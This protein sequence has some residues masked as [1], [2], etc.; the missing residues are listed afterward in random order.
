VTTTTLL[1]G[2][3]IRA[4]FFLFKPQVGSELQCIVS[5][6]EEGIITCLAHGVFK[7]E[8][9]NPPKCWETVFVGQTITAKVLVVEQLAWQ[10][11]RILASLLGVTDDHNVPH[12]IDV[13]D[14]F[15]TNDFESVTDSGMFEYEHHQVSSSASHSR[16]GDIAIAGGD[17]APSIYSKKRKAA[18]D[19]SA[20]EATPS[21]V[22]KKAKTNKKSSP[23]VSE[24]VT[25]S[26]KRTRSIS[27]SSVDS[28]TSPTSQSSSSEPNT[29]SVFPVPHHPVPAQ[30]MPP[31]VAT[32]P[33]KQKKD[34]PPPSPVKIV[35]LPVVT[36]PDK[37]KQMSKKSPSKILTKILPKPSIDQDSD[38]DDDA[39]TGISTKAT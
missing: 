33:T 32:S 13:V 28:D 19:R 35:Q 10:E 30:S 24:S 31:P 37:D 14:E 16:G 9:I 39:T 29:D 7:V 5:K 1:Q 8:V 18:E 23:D 17:I 34:P 22:K 12:C 21:P 11:P 38:S 20:S 2:V 15:D 25:K 26:S 27:K 36:W 3:Y 4:Q 6:K